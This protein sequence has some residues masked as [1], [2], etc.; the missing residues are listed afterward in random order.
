MSKEFL[1]SV[2]KMLF[3]HTYKDD[4]NRIYSIEGISLEGCSEPMIMIKLGRDAYTLQSKITF[5][6]FFEHQTF[7]LN[8]S[9]LVKKTCC[10]GCVNT[11]RKNSGY[12]CNRNVI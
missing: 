2:A 3:N 12:T 8:F 5:D 1:D 6:Q 7:D 4:K 11:G 10:E 9:P